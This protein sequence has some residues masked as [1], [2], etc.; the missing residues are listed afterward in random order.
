MLIVFKQLIILLFLYLLVNCVLAEPLLVTNNRYWD[1]KTKIY[2]GNCEKKSGFLKIPNLFLLKQ[3]FNGNSNTENLSNIVY[4]DIIHVNKNNHEYIYAITKGDENNPSY[5][6]FFNLDSP[7]KNECYSF[8]RCFNEAY[9]SVGQTTILNE[10]R[11]Y[12]CITANESDQKSFAT[13]FNITNPNELLKPIKNFEEGF[14]GMMK[15]LCRGIF[16]KY[17][18]NQFALVLGG[19]ETTGCIGILCLTEGNKWLNP[20]L[21][22]NQMIK[23]RTD[24]KSAIAYLMSIDKEQSGLASQL[25]LWD[26]GCNLWSFN[27]KEPQS[28]FTLLHTDTVLFKSSTTTEKGQGLIATRNLKSPGITFYYLNNSSQGKSNALTKLELSSNNSKITPDIQHKEFD[29][30]NLHSLYLRFGRLIL[31]PKLIS[32]SQVPSVVELNNESKCLNYPWQF[33]ISTG[34]AQQLIQTK[35]LWDPK[36]KKEVLVT[37]DQKCDLNILQAEVTRHKYG[38]LVFRACQ[39]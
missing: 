38:R 35:L 6:I 8:N 15:N 29:K 4:L 27:L 1:E 33:L 28:G 25:I 31:V 30:N 7:Y 21:F 20:N 16:F 32:S 37:L 36:N 14:Q 23:Y 34:E 18:V 22:S 10:E 19:L 39:K 11:H 17:N 26:R 24:K 2:I 12:L 9:L 3:E 13:L 5:L